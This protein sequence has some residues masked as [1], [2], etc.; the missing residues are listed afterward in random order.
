MSRGILIV[1]VVALLFASC[2]PADERV[3]IIG[4]NQVPCVQGSPEPCYLIKGSASEP[5]I[6][7][8]STIESLEP[9][10]GYQYTVLV[11]ERDRVT[12]DQPVPKVTFLV[13]DVIE[14]R[15]VM[16]RIKWYYG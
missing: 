12:A 11:R 14:K 3:V 10:D 2:A 15:E 1:L 6:V 7:M 16:G 13:V 4:P 8:D 5:W 9:E